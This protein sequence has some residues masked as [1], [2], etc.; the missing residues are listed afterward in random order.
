[1]TTPP[2][3]APPAPSSQ[4]R[5]R[6]SEVLDA[7]QSAVVL[8]DAD[9]RLISANRDFLQVY[10]Q[11][12]PVM[13]PGVRFEDALRATVAAGLVPE[14]AADPEAWVQRRLAL[15][16]QPQGPMLREMPDGRWRRIVEQR[17]SDGSLLA[18]SVDVTELVAARRELAL[19]RQEAEQARQR[20]EDAVE[21]LP[22]GF[23]LYDA[24]DRL[25]MVNRTAR[26]MY[27]QLA[28]LPAERPRFEDVVRANYQRGGL[29]EF[30]TPE[31]FESWLARR[32]EARRQPSAAHL[33]AASGGRWVRVHERRMRDGGLVGV[34]IDVTAEVV[35]RAAAEQATQRLQDAID[36]LPEAFALFDADDRLVVWNE[37]YAQT[38]ARS[39]TRI[40]AGA[41]FV[42]MLLLG[43]A[44][45]QYPQARGREEAW[46]AERL[47][48]HRHPAG[49]LLQELPDNRW[50]RI[51][52]RRTRD[53]G[54]AGVRSDV[55][56]L[57][58]R[59][60]ALTALN[61][62]LDELNAELSRLSNTDELTGLA[63]RRHFD[64]RLAEECARAARH[65]TPLALLMLDVDHFKRYNDR[66]GH[67]AGDTCLQA[68]A[69]ALSAS[70]RRPTDL[71][72]RFGGEEFAMLLP[73]QTADEAR[74]QAERC[75]A[76]LQAAALVHGD[77]PVSPWVT[78]STGVA[79]VTGRPA[80]PSAA[81]IAA[82]LLRAAD[83][84]LYRAKLA[85][86]NRVVMS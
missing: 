9:D 58:L 13:Q 76:A 60:Q 19:A 18:H 11:V 48:A 34:R 7:M 57:V 70:A 64:R 53:G 75:A 79:Q 45:G 81:D 49:P 42:E 46:L 74:A 5:P 85:G 33:M 67:L 4:N 1:V 27:P 44:Q 83:A 66:H 71:V 55:T 31:A 69:A 25:Q 41:P 62:R 26:E 3:S 12:A 65:G 78:L 24:D 30:H 61:R 28:D 80:G 36:A 77:S 63:N 32:L 29:P 47:Q 14:A 23:E 8:W 39:A 10:A 52:E 73:H 50:V 84:A 38:Y 82:E 37:R 20:L 68:V 35:G 51:E 21:A 17:L 86:R 43:L 6:L 15:R 40:R 59:E 22:A 54:V 72:A 56:E 16:R 2:A